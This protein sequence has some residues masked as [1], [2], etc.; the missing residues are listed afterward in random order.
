MNPKPAISVIIC[1]INAGKFARVSDC[2]RHLLADYPFEIIGIHDAKSLAGAY[3]AAM[4][5]ATGDILIFSHDDILILDNQFANKIVDR[6]KDYDLL[7]FAGTSRLI[8]GVWS[9]AGQPHIHGVIS[10]AK[11]GSPRLTLDIF[12]V[13][14][15]PVVDGI[16]A[17]DG[18]CL[19]TRRDVAEKIGFDAL[20]FD[21]FHHYDADF[22][23]AAHLTGFRLGVCCDI[24][25]IH[26]SSGVFGSD[27]HQKY[28]AR[29]R[30][31]YRDVLPEC[32]ERPPQGPAA[33][34]GAPLADSDAVLRA[35][36]P[37]IL[38]RATVAMRR[39]F[40]APSA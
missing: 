34:R 17:M 40:A 4:Q 2:Y 12:G 35:W 18:V 30:D 28:E 25:L 1:S 24:P 22:S 20:R 11:T 16:Q 7:G 8:D 27:D 6:L 38:K 23:F 31:K 32:I 3:N 14:Q 36:Q 19:I 33:G 5:R 26:E 21:G 13:G 37:E 15:W 29:F 9:S 39:Q 10:H